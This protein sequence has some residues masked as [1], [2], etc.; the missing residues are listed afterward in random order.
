MSQPTRLVHEP[1][2]SPR[3]S[4]ARVRVLPLVGGNHDGR[5]IG[6]TLHSLLYATTGGGA[7]VVAPT[8]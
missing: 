3:G 6:G 5:V 7:T 2:A 8:R 4:R 1:E